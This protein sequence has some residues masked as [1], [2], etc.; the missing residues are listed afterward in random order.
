M[1]LRKLGTYFNAATLRKADVYKDTDWNEYRVK[2]YIA[3][4]HQTEADYHTDDKNEANENAINFIN[5]QGV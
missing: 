1:A 5:S 2:F 4:E 3:G